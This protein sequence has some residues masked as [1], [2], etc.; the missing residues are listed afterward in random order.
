MNE[1]PMLCTNFTA[2]SFVGPDLL[3]IEVLRCR[4]RDFYVFFAAMTLTLTL[5]SV[6]TNLIHVPLYLLR[7]SPQTINLGFRMLYY[8]HT[9]THAQ[10]KLP[11]RFTDGSK[12]KFNWWLFDTSLG[13]I[14][15]LL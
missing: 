1:K 6:Y 13:P 3:P 9:V 2:I 12:W 15:W 11:C 14:C 8:I 4:N 5:W 10:A 7:I